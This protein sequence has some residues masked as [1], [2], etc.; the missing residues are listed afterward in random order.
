M[1]RRDFT[2]LLGSRLLGVAGAVG[3]ASARSL[4]DLR[5]GEFSVADAELADPSPVPSDVTIEHWRA[6]QNAG[7][8]WFEKSELVGDAWRSVGMTLPVN[9]QSGHPI[10]GRDCAAYLLEADVPGEVLEAAARGAI[11]VCLA[12]E[13]AEPGPAATPERKAADGRPVSRWLRNLSDTQLRV[14]LA[15]FEPPR[16]DVSGMTFFEH[17]TRDHGFATSAVACLTDAEQA[18]LHGAAHA[19]Y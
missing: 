1:N 12:Q 4:L 7:W 8:R 11:D 6:A 3:T 9:R 10:S 18:K 16:A 5:F 14:W 15:S 13:G 2:R 19:G 17:L